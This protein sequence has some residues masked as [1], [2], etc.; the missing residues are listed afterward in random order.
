MEIDEKTL[1]NQK[2]SERAHTSLDPDPFLVSAYEEFLSG[3]PAGS[4]L[5]VA[6]GAGRHSIWLAQRGWRANLLDISDVGIGLAEKNASRALGPIRKEF[7]IH[8]EVADLNRVKDLGTEQ[9][10]LV[11]VFFYLQRELFPA[12]IT[13]L[14]PGGFLLYKTYTTDQQRFTGG[15][16]NP[17]FLLKPNELLDAFQSLRVLHYH[18]TAQNK[19]TAELVA[20]K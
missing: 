1:W 8:A 20:Q 16:S 13:A 5:D 11:L 6:G 15:P 9:F 18:E 3:R 10:D 7:L 12:L 2:F 4:V 14:R 19:G 17:A